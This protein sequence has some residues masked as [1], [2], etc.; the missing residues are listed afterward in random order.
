[1][2]ED[3]ARPEPDVVEV[4]DVEQ[5]EIRVMRSCMRATR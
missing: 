2:G 3:L 4:V 1:M 5:L